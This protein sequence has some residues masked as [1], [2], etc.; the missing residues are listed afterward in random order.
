MIH[1]LFR[2]ERTLLGAPC[3][4]SRPLYRQPS[5][6]SQKSPSAEVDFFVRER[7]GALAHE[8]PS[9]IRPGAACRFLGCASRRAHGVAR[10][11]AGVARRAPGASRRAGGVA[12]RASGSPRRAGGVGRRAPGSPRR[13]AGVARRARGTPRRARGVARQALGASRRAGGVL[14]RRRSVSRRPGGE[15]ARSYAEHVDERSQR[16]P[17]RGPR[18]AQRREIG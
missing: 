2:N 18:W 16:R 15:R 4:A 5:S 6:R 12:R 8:N 14:R 17:A 13:A 3:S 11:A 1:S 7:A 9:S 10:R